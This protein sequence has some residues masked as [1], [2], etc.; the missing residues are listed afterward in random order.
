MIRARLALPVLLLLAP[1]T[2][3]RKIPLTSPKALPAGTLVLRFS[4][5]LKGNLE[6]TLDD[7]RV[8]VTMAKKK[9]NALVITGLSTGLHRY[10]LTGPQDAFGPA[11]GEVSLP[12]DRG[13]YEVVLAQRLDAVLYGKPAAALP[14]QA[15]PGITARL[16]KW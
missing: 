8:P 1:A 12:D 6:L 11:G 13:V 15:Q 10:F 2:A 7:A 4:R 5:E 14:A 16:E 3:C 9:G